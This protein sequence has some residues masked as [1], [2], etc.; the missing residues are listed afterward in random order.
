[1]MRHWIAGFALI[2]SLGVAQD[3]PAGRAQQAVAEAERLFTTSLNAGS[4]AFPAAIAK[5]ETALEL[6]RGLGDRAAMCRI[7]LRIGDIQELLGAYEAQLEANERALALATAIGEVKLEI[8]A[9]I[10][11]GNSHGSLGDYQKKI[12]YANRALPLTR[13][14]GDVQAQSQVLGMFG[15]YYLLLGDFRRA[16]EIATERVAVSRAGGSRSGEMQALRGLANALR[17]AGDYKKSL[18]TYSQAFDIAIEIRQPNQQAT[19]LQGIGGVHMQFG[20]YVEA[21]DSYEKS[22]KIFVE[23]LPTLP[24]MQSVTLLLAGNALLK[25]SQT[26]RA[27]EYLR[28]A[29]EP[30][31]RF[32]EVWAVTIAEQAAPLY[33]A[34]G[35]PALALEHYRRA[36]SKYELSE[37]WQS[38]ADVLAGMARAE[39]DLGDLD[40]ARRDIETAISAVESVRAKISAPELRAT[41]LARYHEW[42]A[43]DIDLMMSMHPRGN[44]AFEASDRG[45]AKSLVE[46]L[47]QGHVNVSS[48]ASAA[49][50]QRRREVAASLNAAFVRKQQLND[51][52]HL[53][54]AAEID[55]QAK[56]LTSEYEELEAQFQAQSPEYRGLTTPP[57]ISIGEIQR[58]LDGETVFLEYSLGE[59][60]SYAWLVGKNTFSSAELPSRPAI[61]A[62]ARRTYEVLTARNRHPLGE[63]PAA[64]RA[65]V[66]GADAQYAVESNALSR[67]ILTPLARELRLKHRIIVAAD[68]ALQYV[69]FAGLPLADG[70]PLIEEHEVVGIPSASVLS[71]LLRGT[72]ITRRP[73]GALA[74]IADPVFDRRDER[75]AGHC[76]NCPAGGLSY[77]T[78][79]SALDVALLSGTRIP[80]LPF[81][82]KEAERISAIAAP[83]AVWKRL[84]FSAR[85]EVF[86][87]P[88]IS[89]YGILHIATHGIFDSEH[90]ELSGV[91][92]S[93]V[94]KDGR[95]QD[96]FLRLNDIY[97]LRLNARLVVLSACQTAL[98]KEINGEGLIGVTRGFFN[99]GASTVIASLWKVDDVATAALMPAFY[100]GLLRNRLA[101]SAALRAAQIEI[102]KQERFS[103]PYFWAAFTLQGDWK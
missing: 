20:H 51:A 23:S 45:R 86:W 4:A 99:A 22:L 16:A 59:S 31:P 42:Q 49:L 73:S 66:A 8:A 56:Q 44:E 37:N 48:G 87:G 29:V 43:F 40:G 77:D 39:R 92:L 2:V 38:R 12:A 93:L 18:D 58:L 60:K 97:N 85:K 53:R 71:L 10:G 72:R 103:A 83:S 34:L 62:A 90:P 94:D 15:G 98:G 30:L 28:R 102:R 52:G 88:E 57:D 36:L 46:V 100:Q 74:L 55:Q 13:K 1:M 26:E 101:P 80:R 76:V 70:K 25:L 84:D 89:R 54:E 17:L 65:R 91:V 5:Y 63:T 9:L 68:G 81:T 96:G 82:R 75:V 33:R 78:E 32:S 7:L 41:Y 47:A 79:R 24:H 11:A 35:E 21:L 27:R 61:E 69:P 3:G 14:S 67:M 95:G 50:L 19:L 64:R 6:Y